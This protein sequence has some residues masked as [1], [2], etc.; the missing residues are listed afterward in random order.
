MSTIEDD[1]PSTEREPA[2]AANSTPL[3]YDKTPSPKRIESPPKTPASTTAPSTTAS[4][5][6][7]YDED[8][9]ANI[10]GTPMT[11][12][13]SQ[14][15]PDDDSDEGYAETTTSSYVTSIASNIRRGIIENGRRYAAYG[16]N[17]PWVPIDD[18]EVNHALT[19]TACLT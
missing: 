5:F 7:S 14:I 13:S 11:A 3:T 18:S 12:N 16:Q 2:E 8:D 9:D 1:I 17:K 15:E 4:T 10:P 6:V 19:S